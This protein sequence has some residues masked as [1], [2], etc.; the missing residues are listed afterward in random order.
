MVKESNFRILVWRRNQIEWLQNV[1]VVEDWISA[2]FWYGEEIKLNNYRMFLWWKN[3]IEKLQNVGV[4]NQTGNEGIKFQ[5]IGV[6]KESNFR[7]LVWWRNQIEWSQNGVVEESNWTIQ[8]LWCGM[9]SNHIIKECW[10]GGEHEKFCS[11]KAIKFVCV[12][13]NFF[14]PGWNIWTIWY[15]VLCHTT[16]A[17]CFSLVR[18]MLF[19]SVASSPK[20]RKHHKIHGIEPLFNV[21]NKKF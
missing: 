2:E 18:V 13:L 14:L 11:H 4:M 19:C 17:T 15:W 1:G 12:R 20:S 16:D 21:G 8:E 9:I 3:Q 5:N 6:M 10:G 7:I